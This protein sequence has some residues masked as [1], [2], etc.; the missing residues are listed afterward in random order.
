M[1]YSPRSPEV[2]ELSSLEVPFQDTVLVLATISP[3]GSL[4]IDFNISVIHL[5][6]QPISH[7]SGTGQLGDTWKNCRDCYFHL[8]PRKLT[9]SEG[10][11]RR[12]SLV[13][14]DARIT[15]SARTDRS[16]PGSMLPWWSVEGGPRKTTDNSWPPLHKFLSPNCRDCLCERWYAQIISFVI[17]TTIA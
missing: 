16:A 6:W 7:N 10:F 11:F 13:V 8:S 5:K 2:K 17:Y 1:K 9:V 15:F 4:S 3:W 14:C 12:F